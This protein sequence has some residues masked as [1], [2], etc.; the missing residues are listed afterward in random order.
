MAN[1]INIEVEIVDVLNVDVTFPRVGTLFT[2]IQDTLDGNGTTI[3]Q[4]EL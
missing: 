3:L 1:E 4:D 2:G